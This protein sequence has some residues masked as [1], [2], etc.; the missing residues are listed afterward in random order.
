MF[1]GLFGLGP[2]WLKSEAWS[3]PS[4]VLMQMFLVAAEWLSSAALR[5]VPAQL[6]ESAEIDGASAWTKFIKI[7]L[8]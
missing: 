6:Y 5:N 3:K 2:S 8:P 1:L 7:T 4:L